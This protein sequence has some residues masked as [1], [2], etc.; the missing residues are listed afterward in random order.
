MLKIIFYVFDVY[1]PNFWVFNSYYYQIFLTKNQNVFNI[2]NTIGY[3]TD[4]AFWHPQ[5]SAVHIQ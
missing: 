4:I 3:K 1:L 2:F 5:E